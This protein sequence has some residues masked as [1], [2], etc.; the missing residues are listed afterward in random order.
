MWNNS[1]S[2]ANSEGIPCTSFP[3]HDEYVT[4]SHIVQDPEDLSFSSVFMLSNFIFT[5]LTSNI[6]N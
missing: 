1:I 4:C 2:V 6:V 5:A 3:A